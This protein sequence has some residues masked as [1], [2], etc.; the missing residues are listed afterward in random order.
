M[1]K[2]INETASGGSVGAASVAVNMSRMGDTARRN[3]RTTDYTYSNDIKREKERE[4]SRKSE[5]ARYKLMREKLSKIKKKKGIKEF[6]KRKIFREAIDLNDVISRLRGAQRTAAGY[7]DDVIS[8]GVEDDN[9]N[10]MRITIRSKQAK[11][12]EYILARELE[13]YKENRL[14]GSF[15]DDKSLAEILFDLKN[16]FEIVDVKFPIIPTDVVYN[17]NQTTKVTPE[18]ESQE[19]NFSDDET[20]ESDPEQ[21]F[22]KEFEKDEESGG[23]PSDDEES[24]ENENEEDEMPSGEDVA[25]DFEEPQNN[26]TSLLKN[27]IDMIKSQADAAKATAEAEAEKARAKQAEFTALGVQSSLEREEKM[28]KVKAQI[29]EQKEK[30]KRAKEI[31]ELAR[32][33]V[34]K[35][36]GAFDF[37]ESI[38]YD[39]LQEF[40]NNPDI[41]YED[42]IDSTKI[43]NMERDL[44]KKYARNPQ[45]DPST[46]SYKQQQ[47][48]L[49]LKELN[50]RKQRATLK[51]RYDDSAAKNLG[52]F[53]KNQ[54]NINLNS[55]NQN[56]TPNN[57]GQQKPI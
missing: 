23:I 14:N 32:Y 17:A 48:E 56:M 50:S 54:R 3:L 30:E 2:R 12:F 16:K 26:E 1:K 20:L 24:G 21:K 45:D 10:I 6:L 44:R 7:N 55:F 13:K 9:G 41:D 22:S 57:A 42:Y 19:E 4:E 46:I 29:E 36:N 37:K 51:K 15:V 35:T 33:N 53:D 11:D 49:S 27:I 28:A 31:A 8:Y 34:Q 40:D 38:I 25:K 43:Q 18:Q 39:I 47:L 52:N 5:E